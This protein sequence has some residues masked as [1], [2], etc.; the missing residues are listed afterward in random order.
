MDRP[1][2]LAALELNNSGLHGDANATF[3]NITHTLYDAPC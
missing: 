3:A 1:K 2:L